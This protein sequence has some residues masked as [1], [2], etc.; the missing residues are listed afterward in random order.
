MAITD[1]GLRDSI[2]TLSGMEDIINNMPEDPNIDKTDLIN[3][4]KAK[5]LLLAQAFNDYYKANMEI[6]GISSTV[7]A[8]IGVQVVPATGT[9]STITPGTATQ[10]T[11][12]KP[13]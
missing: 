7:A 9:G 3:Q 2:Y 6:A 13:I 11:S 10:T 8:G 12:V 1:T 5:M 4:T